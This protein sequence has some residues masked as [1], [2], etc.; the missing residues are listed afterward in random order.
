MT[1][2]YYIA[3]P[4]C[5]FFFAALKEFGYEYANFDGAWMAKERD[6]QLGGMLAL[7][8]GAAGDPELGAVVDSVEFPERNELVDVEL[9][10]CVRETALSLALPPPAQGGRD[11]LEITIP[12]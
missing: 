1:H 7:Q 11:E 12:I 5:F 9:L 8:I 10:E 6:P 4:P 2:L 3:H